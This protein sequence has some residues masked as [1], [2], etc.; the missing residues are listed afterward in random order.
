VRQV[1]VECNN[2]Q[3]VQF[4]ASLVQRFVTQEGI[5]GN[6]VLICDEQH[7]NSRPAS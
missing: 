4:P 5:R 3:K 7:K 2:G 1:L 6:F